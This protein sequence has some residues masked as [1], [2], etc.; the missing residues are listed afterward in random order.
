MQPSQTASRKNRTNRPVRILFAAAAL[1]TAS[2]AAS[3]QAADVNWD[4]GSSNFVWDTLSLNWTGA[5]WNNAAGD[6]AIFGPTGA[7]AI[8][9]PGPINVNSM[10]FTA[11]GYTLSGAGPFNIVAGTSTQTTGVVAAQTGV[12]AQINVPINSAL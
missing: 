10:N 7:G 5:A 8:S 11:N 4:N 9:V 3:A 1:A 6:G 2:L 12:T